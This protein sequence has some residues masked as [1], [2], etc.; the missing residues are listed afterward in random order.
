MDALTD[1][2]DSVRLASSLYCRVHISAPWGL[3][4]LASPYAVFHVVD[5]GNCW[6]RVA[7]QTEPVPLSGGDLVILTHGAAHQ[8]ID[9]LTTPATVDIQIGETTSLEFQTLEYVF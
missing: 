9:S 3:N 7:G 1:V 5:R 8:I 4:F 2:L 6:L